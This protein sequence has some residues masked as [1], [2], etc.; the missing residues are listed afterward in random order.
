M[1]WYYNSNTGAV[2]QM[3]SPIG[4]VQLSLGIGWHG[5]FNSKQDALDYY[6]NNAAKNPGWKQPTGW[7]GNITN[8]PSAAGNVASNALDPFKG[9][10]L[11]NWFIRIGEVLLGLVLVGVGVAKLTGTAN[12]ISKFAKVPL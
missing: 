9:L 10:N 2:V 11:G 5:P 1:N 8:I 4:S 7:V 12:V 6:T 3:P